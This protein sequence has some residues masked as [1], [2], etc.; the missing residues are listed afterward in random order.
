MVVAQPI[1]APEAPQARQAVASLGGYAYQ[2]YA[3]ALAWLRLPTDAVLFL[4]IA[5]DYATVAADAMTGTQVKQEQG[6][7][8]LNSPGVIQ[9]IDD[10]V[11]LVR[12][13]PDRLVQFEF[14]TTA[15]PTTERAL[16]DRVDGLGGIAAWRSVAEGGPIGPL[17][18]RL[19]AMELKPGTKAYLAGLD[20]GGF[21]SDLVQ[22]ITWATGA[23]SSEALFKRFQDGLL[24][25]GRPRGIPAKV[26]DGAAYQI[27]GWLLRFITEDEER[28]LS[29]ADLLRLFDEV[30]RETVPSGTVSRVATALG[31]SLP[32]QATGLQVAGSVLEPLP[33][34]G[35]SGLVIARP[36]LE[37]DCK[38][39]VRGSAGLWLHGGVG[40]GKT[41]TAT[42]VAAPLERPWFVLRL[43][44]QP[45]E[46]ARAW[47]DQARIETSVAVPGGVLID[48]LPPEL[49]VVGDALTRLADGLRTDDVPFIV[50]SGLPPELANR[51]RLGLPA[52]A[53]HRVPEL[54][55][56]EVASLVELAGGDPVLWA[57][58]VYLSSGGGHP[59][60][61]QALTIDLRDRGWP[62][63]EVQSLDALLGVNAGLEATREV[64]RRRLMT[65]LCDE[66]RA[67]LYRSS[68]VIGT[69]TNDIRSAIAGVSPAV[70]FPGDAATALSG[71][72]LE[73]ASNGY[74]VSPL[75]SRAGHQGLGQGEVVATHAAVA[76]SLVEG[77]QIEGGDI[78]RIIVH[79]LAGDAED[80][81][82]FI[83]MGLLTLYHDEAKRLAVIAPM[84]TLRTDQPL[85]R[86]SPYVAAM[87]R[88]AQLFLAAADEDQSVTGFR[89]IEA[90]F[91]DEVEAIEASDLR[92]M[93]RALIGSKVLL[94]A[95]YA[96]K[97]ENFVDTLERMA[98][99]P[100]ELPKT[101]EGPDG[102]ALE[103]T[104]F[105]ASFQ[106]SGSP[107]VEAATQAIHSLLE[108]D[109][110]TASDVLTLL[111]E[112]VYD[113]YVSLLTPWSRAVKS[114]D[115]LNDA[116]TDA[117]V[118]LAEAL[119]D[120]G[121]KKLATLG[122]CAA[123]TAADETNGDQ[124]RALTI[125]DKA[126]VYAADDPEILRVRSRV[127]LHAD[128]IDEQLALV[129]DDLDKLAS[130]NPIAAAFF[131]REVAIGQS[132]NDRP[133]DAAATLLKA[134]EKGGGK[135][136]LPLKACLL[137][138]AGVEFWRAGQVASA[139]APLGRG[140]EVTCEMS[141]D[142][143]PQEA[144]AIRLCGA[145]IC[146]IWS[147]AKGGSRPIDSQDVPGPAF[148]SAN[149]DNAKMADFRPVAGAAPV[150]M[151][152]DLE[153][154]AG[155]E[156]EYAQR[157]D[158][159]PIDERLPLYDVLCAT[160]EIIESVRELD[161]ERFKQFVPTASLLSLLPRTP[162]DQELG[163]PGEFMTGG[164]LL[165]R[166]LTDV[167]QHIRQEAAATF[168]MQI[169]LRLLAHRSGVG[170][171]SLLTDLRAAT[172]PLV[173]DVLDVAFQGKV[174]TID[175]TLVTASVTQAASLG[176]LTMAVSGH[177]IRVEFIAEAFLRLFETMRSSPNADLLLS[178][179]F[180]VARTV[181][182]GAL[183][184]QS[185]LLRNPVRA[186]P[187]INEV[188]KQQGT[189]KLRISDLL[190]L[191]ID[192]TGLRIA[193]E[194]RE[195]I[196]SY[197]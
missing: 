163:D 9:A 140:Y 65:S 174:A 157:R 137:V 108:S 14:L 33:D 101:I 95:G 156:A 168:A 124:D 68:I 130:N 69:V 56:A 192:A 82:S 22:R 96:A 132:R 88:A 103:I 194:F 86:R 60:L 18:S 143:G 136:G 175:D 8:T 107:S 55:E 117:Y 61:A 112:P 3:S 98:E 152:A 158:T 1:E 11:Q 30:T 195:M 34:Q 99:T 118:G 40:Y 164:G 120:A 92:D 131:L 80:V 41:T 51:D 155:Q 2:L 113:F 142:V 26:A 23:P 196:R 7:I 53:V 159:L 64:A 126:N 170:I 84:A 87:L 128:R 35:S 15:E 24:D 147:Q 109:S 66:H 73:P 151:L 76:R 119:Q 93:L 187:A 62:L 29:A 21:R 81:L 54:T 19:E 57:K 139:I 121:H 38:R 6:T 116:A 197:A 89:E 179:V 27:C 122:F 70:R 114:G 72:W 165:S 85:H 123:A 102:E 190:L 79:G 176:V 67:M 97:S 169:A 16:G 125:L 91:N 172:P 148:A 71:S 115:P 44:S 150:Y 129:E 90:A 4:E 25:L 141:A 149:Y 110:E 39:A 106:V 111:R 153:R 133:A 144:A 193:A 135:I 183:E 167:E 182:P 188:L 42:R 37:A 48:D 49:F 32:A 31:Q 154:R 127:L 184:E 50:T 189:D 63:E 28:R 185:F 162:A 36:T 191:L 43:R 180:E 59:Q 52:D 134:V 100:S 13:N 171:A 178:D 12:D 145:Q 94:C 5:E 77:P 146:L 20:D 138:D 46:I 177:K 83:S 45:P 10:F 47:L 105:L 75:V 78:P 166:D 160:E 161:V 17:R 104:P 58:Y 181:L 74:R 173:S 186:I